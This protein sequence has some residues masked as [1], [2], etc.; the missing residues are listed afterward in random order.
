MLKLKK[1]RV[2]ND[3]A[4]RSVKLTEEYNNSI[5]KDEKRKQYLLQSVSKHRKT[6]TITSKATLL[7]IFFYFSNKF[8]NT[9]IKMYQ[10][11]KKIV[12]INS[13]LVS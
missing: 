11:G 7:T 4:E 12:I 9:L 1:I 13:L 3:T 6:Y 2:V 5:T 10:Y 8:K